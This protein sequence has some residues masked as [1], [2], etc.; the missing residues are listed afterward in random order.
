MIVAGGWLLALSA[1][2]R[3][4]SVTRPLPSAST[5]AHVQEFASLSVADRTAAAMAL[6]GARSPCDPVRA[7]AL[8]AAAVDDRER[9][10]LRI[11][12]S[13]GFFAR[14][15]KSL[16]ER[17]KPARLSATGPRQR[18]VLIV[19]EHCDGFLLEK[20]VDSE[21]GKTAVALGFDRV[22]CQH[23]GLTIEAA[24]AP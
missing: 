3:D 21:D 2:R 23:Q 13:P 15:E 17:M 19:T 5:N 24:L 20:F 16:R 6:C 22:K 4:E 14:A 8:L 12:A 1:C 11:A 7:R 9:D 10:A 18:T